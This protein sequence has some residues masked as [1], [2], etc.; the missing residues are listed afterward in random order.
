V[1]GAG[2]EAIG[3]ADG[4]AAMALALAA[5]V[6]APVAADTSPASGLPASSGSNLKITTSELLIS[7]PFAQ[8]NKG[9]AASASRPT[10]RKPGI[11][12]KEAM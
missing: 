11:T 1:A 7:S 6:A 2:L 5:G 12:N 8:P 4:V 3:A 10:C 9:S